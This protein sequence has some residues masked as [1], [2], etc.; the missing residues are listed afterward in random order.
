MLF[1]VTIAE[2]LCGAAH[3]NRQAH[4]LTNTEFSLS[5]AAGV[6]PPTA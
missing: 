2:G 5:E 1:P 6:L 3:A 4:T